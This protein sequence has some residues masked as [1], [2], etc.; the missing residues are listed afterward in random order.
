MITNFKL[1]EYN[2]KYNLP[3][4]LYHGSNTIHDFTK[5]GDV[6]NKGGTFLATSQF[7]ANVFGENIFK[8]KLKPNLNLFNS[9][10]ISDCE[11][12]FNYVNDLINNKSFFTIDYPIDNTIIIHNP[13]EL[14]TYRDNWKILEKNIV[15]KWLLNNYDGVILTEMNSKNVFLKSPVH[16][17]ILSYELI[18]R[19]T[20]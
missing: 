1:F 6:Y 12:L 16:N 18:E 2:N 13:E 9:T 11:L 5:T 19:P 15:W 14:A 7:H 4:Y 20:Q 17:K 8:V 3:E 10:Q